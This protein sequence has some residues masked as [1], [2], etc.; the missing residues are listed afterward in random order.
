M[1]K[2]QR[3]IPAAAY[4]RMSSDKQEASIPTQRTVV[5]E[6]AA[7]RG[8]KIV[9]AYIDERI[10]GDATEKGLQFQRMIKD[11]AKGRFKAILC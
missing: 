8:Y 6:Y 11:A 10:S 1:I 7:E 5:E 4:Y 3:A 9:R 2:R